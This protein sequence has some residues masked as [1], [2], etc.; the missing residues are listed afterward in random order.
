MERVG[1]EGPDADASGFLAGGKRY[2]RLFCLL[3]CRKFS[4][5]PRSAGDRIPTRNRTL[6]YAEYAGEYLAVS[7]T[8]LLCLTACAACL[9]ASA[10]TPPAA[11]SPA[12]TAFAW[13]R[14]SLRSTPGS[15]WTTRGISVSRSSRR[16]W[17]PISPQYRF[18]NCQPDIP[19]AAS[20]ARVS[21]S[22]AT[23]E[24]SPSCSRLRPACQTGFSAGRSDPQDLRGRRSS[25]IRDTASTRRRHTLARIRSSGSTNLALPVLSCLALRRRLSHVCVCPAPLLRGGGS[26]PP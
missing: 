25:S 9:L 5:A 24:P 2:P 8:C 10:V 20:T 11:G 3:T 12:G 18:A 22:L 13:T 7:R 14:R 6:K 19:T 21:S 1:F 17:L 16:P 26:L 23:P 4:A 15:R